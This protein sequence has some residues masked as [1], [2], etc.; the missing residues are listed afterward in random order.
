MIIKDTEIRYSLR[1]QV[2]YEQMT[3]RPYDGSRP[4]TDLTILLYSALITA[5]EPAKGLTYEELLDWLDEHP[6]ELRRFGEWLKEE[7]ARV[8]QLTAEP[9][10]AGKKK[11]P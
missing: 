2:A 6:S 10:E 4:I 5:K 8:Q 3:G 7:G 11:E 1:M 9:A